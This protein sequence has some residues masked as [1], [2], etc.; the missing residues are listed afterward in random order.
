M[1]P[2]IQQNVHSHP[3]SLFVFPGDYQRENNYLRQFQ[4]RWPFDA[5]I[6]SHFSVQQRSHRQL[7]L[8]FL[9]RSTFRFSFLLYSS[10]SFLFLL[11]WSLLL[12]RPQLGT[13]KFYI[14]KSFLFMTSFLNVDYRRFNPEW[15]KFLAAEVFIWSNGEAFEFPR[16]KEKLERAYSLLWVNLCL[17]SRRNFRL[18]WM[19]W[20]WHRNCRFCKTFS[21]WN[22]V[23]EKIVE[24]SYI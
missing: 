19:G 17:C 3:K 23:V 8:Q 11:Q 15:F 24:V 9:S 13:L 14:Q 7:V 6:G 18:H 21:E 4:K 16:R 10:L 22:V 2:E 5:N 20:G 1:W 12:Q